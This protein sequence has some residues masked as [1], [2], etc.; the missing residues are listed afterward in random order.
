[1][2]TTYLSI[3]DGGR[4]AYQKLDGAG[5]CIVFLCGHGSDMFGSKAEALMAYCEEHGRAFVRF[6]YTGHGLSSGAFLDG[7]ISAWTNDAV[8]FNDSSEVLKAFAYAPLTSTLIAMRA[9]MRLANYGCHQS[10]VR[11]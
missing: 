10:H 1:M 2:N 3:A 7:T 4:L 5:P 9:A 6:D 11:N 8:T